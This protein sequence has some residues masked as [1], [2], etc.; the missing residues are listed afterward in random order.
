[1]STSVDENNVSEEK[2][3]ESVEIVPSID[4]ALLVKQKKPRT[5][6]QIRT[7]AENFEIMKAK[8]EWKKRLKDEMNKA[9]TSLNDEYNKRLR[10][11]DETQWKPGVTLVPYEVECQKYE[12]KVDL[13]QTTQKPTPQKRRPPPPPVYEEED[14]YGDEEDVYEEEYEEPPPPPHR[15][16]VQRNVLPPKQVQQRVNQNYDT[17][18]PVKTM[19]APIHPPPCTYNSLPPTTQYFRKPSVSLQNYGGGLF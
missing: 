11:I 10:Y 7:Q 16:P 12:T 19:Q 4:P 6:A 2:K 15:R 3:E 1:M 5:A 18:T 14:D 13:T 9:V 17:Y 8:N